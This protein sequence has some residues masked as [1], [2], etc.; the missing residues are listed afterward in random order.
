MN[1][2]LH[3]HYKKLK[4]QGLTPEQ[5]QKILLEV[6]YPGNHD[7]LTHDSDF[8]IE[9]HQGRIRGPLGIYD[10]HDLVLLQD[11]PYP[12]S[13]TTQNLKS[14]DDLLDRDKQREKD[15]FSRKIRVGKLIKPG[16]GGK[17]KV[18]VVPT[19]VEEKFIHDRV[20]TTEEEQASGGA[21]EG[22]EGEVIGEQ[23]VRGEGAGEGGA[24]HGEEGAHEMESNA[25]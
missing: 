22:Q 20:R 11:M 25:Y 14:I 24:G 7:L 12:Q 6:H 13:N 8:I 21:G 23:P 2:T 19:T 17:D 4:Q 15:G 1:R 16:K 9:P 18:V 10:H 3:E 5:E